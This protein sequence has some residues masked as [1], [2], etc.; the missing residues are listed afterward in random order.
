[1]PARVIQTRAETSHSNNVRLKFLLALRA[2][3]GNHEKSYFHVPILRPV[4]SLARTE[5][6]P[7][8]RKAVVSSGWCACV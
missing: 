3:K 6:V 8:I 1:M 5:Y 7:S 2:R 4:Q